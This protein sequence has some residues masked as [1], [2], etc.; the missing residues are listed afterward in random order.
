MKHLLEAEC[1][2][3]RENAPA[4]TYADGEL[5]RGGL[6]YRLIAGSMHYFRIHPG[7]WHDR[8]ARLA[9]LGVNTLDTYV[10]WNF[11]EKIEGSAQF[12]GW[13]DVERYIELAADAGLDV[14]VRPGPF[15]CAEWDNGGLPAWL[16]GRPGIRLRST[17]PL[18]FDPVQRWFDAL[19]PRLSAL[20]SA[21]GGPIIAFQ[22]E[23]EFGSYGDD[24][25]YLG[26][27]RDSLTDRGITELLYTADGPTERM[28]QAG[29]I[30]GVL[31]TATFGSN[32]LEAARLLRSRRSDEP[33]VCAEFWN[34]W[35][36]H[37][38]EQH[39]VRSAGEAAVVVSDIVESGGSVSIYMAH[40][41]TNFGLWA[42]AN[43]DGTRLQP[44]VTSYDSDAA[45]A[46]NGSLTA[47][48]FALRSTLWPAVQS[49]GFP[50]D[51]RPATLEPRVLKVARRGALL[52]SLVAA[53]HPVAD[54]HPL[55]FESIGQSSGL[56][57]HESRPVLAL[58]ENVIEFTGVHDRAIVYVDGERVG[59]ID[60]VDGNLTIAGSAHSVRLEVLV[61]NQ[62]RINYGPL[63]GQ[64]KGILGRVR[65]NGQDVIGWT[66]RALPLDEWSGEQLADARAG[67]PGGGTG[68]ATAE[69]DVAR[70][71]D[72]FLALPGFGKGFVWVGDALLGR[73]W[74]IGPQRTLYIPAPFL[75][76]GRNVITVLE[77]EH[78]GD[79]V[80]LRD[81]PDLG[82]EEVYVETFE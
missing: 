33:F 56:L 1:N 7:Q 49:G 27:L 24:Q 75:A 51:R 53:S 10:A 25:D 42:G 6:P 82:P 61:E 21:N 72:T 30:P 44:T 79:R 68:F 13:R 29:S 78:F 67:T 60:D 12:A 62:G 28:Q 11:H 8:I 2:R 20:Q 22:V 4:V 23:N 57:L 65:I 45:I 32:P 69:L 15:I 58:G 26:R 18:F 40:G 16:T 64:G 47:K 76:E 41:G 5:L 66:S 3:Q 19:M 55:T 77:L 80:E 54:D 71:A 38:G 81:V 14:V 50:F 52:D 39:H 31:A 37:W 9:D 34:G 48:Y 73:Y 46:E 36:D 17:D 59:V 63:L 35:F 70:P 43:H 74:E